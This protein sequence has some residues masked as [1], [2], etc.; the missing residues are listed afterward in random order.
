MTQKGTGYRLRPQKRAQRA[1][2]ETR[3]LIRAALKKSKGSQRGASRLLG[4]GNNNRALMRMLRGE[5]AE[6][7][8]MRAAVLRA[9]ARA[10]RAFRLLR[11]DVPPQ[12][13]LELVHKLV[14]EVKYKIEVL[15]YLLKAKE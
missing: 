7:P 2:G 10:D 12:V 11:P 13:D 14:A 6:T 8:A 15:E 9:K 5:M 4:L 3:K 1:S